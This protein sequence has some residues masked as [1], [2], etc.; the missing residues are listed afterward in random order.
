MTLIL[1]YECPECGKTIRDTRHIVKRH[2]N[3]PKSDK[4]QLFVLKSV[5][6]D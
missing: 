6:V 1:T 3:C 5:D 2:L 4:P